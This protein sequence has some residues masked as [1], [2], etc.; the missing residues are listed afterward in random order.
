MSVDTGLVLV[1]I[2]VLV[3]L[4]FDFL[5]GFHD[6][7]NSIATVVST[8]VL[9]PTLAVA[10][11]AFFNFIA[12]FF[13]DVKVATTIGKGVVHP[14]IP[15]HWVIL[16]GLLAAILWNLLTWFLGFPS[17]SS[18]ALIGGYAGAAVAPTAIAVPVAAKK[19]P[20]WLI[21]VV[22]VAIL[23][24]VGGS[25]IALSGQGGKAP[26]PTPTTEVVVAAPPTKE[27][28][29]DTPTTAPLTTQLQQ[30]QKDTELHDKAGS[31]PSSRI[32]GL[33]PAGS[34]FFVKARTADSQWIRIETPDG[35]TGWIDAKA[36]GLTG[37]DITSAEVILLE[38]TKE[39]GRRRPHW[40]FPA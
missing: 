34:Q 22:I 24:V 1:I 39:G 30:L 5:N 29:A 28:P 27:A 26:T 14:G 25:V 18:H 37:R 2:T 32:E 7:A 12:A 11:A 8:R 19:R 21:P 16:A 40:S 20:G 6:A 9:S 23:A 13:F 31:D 4:T 38:T 3:A 36:T 15:D 33:L 35:V 17:S 10:W